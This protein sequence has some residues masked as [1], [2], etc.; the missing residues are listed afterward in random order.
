MKRKIA[1]ALGLLGVLGVP[2]APA[3]AAD[4]AAGFYLLGCKIPVTKSLKYFHEFD[5][6]NRLEG[7]SGFLTIT[8]PLSVA[9]Q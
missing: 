1:L 3:F 6:K 7:D 9:G 8:M 5:V 4:G 2:T